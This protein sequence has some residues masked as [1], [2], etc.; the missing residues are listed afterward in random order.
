MTSGFSMTRPL[1]DDPL[2]DVPLR[3]VPAANSEGERLLGPVN[4]QR[5]LSPNKSRRSA[6]LP[7]V[8][9]A[10]HFPPWQTGHKGCR[11]W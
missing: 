1:S 8:L 4:Q 2:R 3:D 6:T 9:V 7:S 11:M 5:L 10:N